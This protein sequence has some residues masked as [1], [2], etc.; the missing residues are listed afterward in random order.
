M[1]F[2]LAQR[3]TVSIGMAGALASAML[4]MASA[5]AQDSSPLSLSD[6]VARLEQQSQGQNQTRMAQVNQLQQMQSQMQQMQG[7]IEELQHQLQQLQDQSKAQYTDLDSRVGRLEKGGASATPAPAANGPASASTTPVATTLG[8]TTPGAPSAGPAPATPPP[9]PTA[10][11]ESAADKAGATTSYNAAF[12]S[13]KAG[14]Y[15]ASSRGFRE[16]IQKYPNDS[17]TPNAFYWLGESYYATTNYQVAVEAFNHLLSQYPQ[18]D[19]APDALLKLGY[20]QLQMK[21]T[22]AGTATLKSVI[23]KYPSSNAAKLAQER[24]TRL[25]QQPAH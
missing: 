6:R 1:T 15:V 8:S 2:K 18:S 14:D 25:S 13:L 20:S 19:K 5:H 16:F 9:A 3:F 12:K 10:P 21:Q 4:F 11:A 24:L 23:A 7:Q 22:D 17:L